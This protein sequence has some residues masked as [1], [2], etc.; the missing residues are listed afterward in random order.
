MCDMSLSS[1][2]ACLQIR[3]REAS[4]SKRNERWKPERQREIEGLQAGGERE[5][6]RE[7]KKEDARAR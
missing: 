4:E 3:T 5:K 6:A 7:R 2:I 1:L